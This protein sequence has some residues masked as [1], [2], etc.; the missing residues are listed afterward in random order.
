MF[1]SDCWPVDRPYVWDGLGVLHG[2]S[3]R[4][5]SRHK[6]LYFVG[7]VRHIKQQI[8]ILLLLDVRHIKQQLK[9]GSIKRLSAPLVSPFN[10]SVLSFWRVHI[11]KSG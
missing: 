7:L 9:S 5:V 4:L 10:P 6:L 2:V 3:R 11:L 8:E 1:L